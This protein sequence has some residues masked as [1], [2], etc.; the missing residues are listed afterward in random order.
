M[1]TIWEFPKPPEP[2]MTRSER[3]F[4]K[5]LFN[6]DQLVVAIPHLRLVL[7]LLEGLEIRIPEHC[8]DQD[9]DLGL[10]LLELS[11]D[12][13]RSAAGR[14]PLQAYARPENPP[15]DALVTYIYKSCEDQYGEWTPTIGKNRTVAE[16][17]RRHTI[18]VGDEGLPVAVQQPQAA[19]DAHP[20][21]GVA[22]G[23]A[24]TV[25]HGNRWLAGAYQA[26]AADL[27]PDPSVLPGFQSGHATFVTG[28]IL[29]EAP[30]ARV[31]V[32]R[33][34][35]DE[36]I[37]DSWS[38]AKAL[39]GFER[40][41]V[42]VLNLSL[43]CFTDDNK[44]PLVLATALNRLDPDIVVVA[45]AGNHAANVAKRRP[46]Y[47]AAIPRV[48]AVGATNCAGDVPAWSPGSAQWPWLDVLATGDGVISTFPEGRVRMPDGEQEYNGY[49][50]WSGT[51]FAAAKVSGAIAARTVPGR[52]DAAT[53]FRELVGS[54]EKRHDLPWI[55]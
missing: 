25:L 43:G 15:L 12:E 50:R 38:V 44:E 9:P 20:G 37:A 52:I 30:G 17:A 4:G 18:G 14:P 16:V 29:Q 26:P 19:R 2:M 1:L 41:G 40:L 51:S 21:G 36:G 31:E 8:V 11:S 6:E 48:V 32:R 27:W 53:A 54:S 22:V 55:R 24:D 3:T 46:I 45:A 47:P 7:G 34:V 28:M 13:L 35:D 49:A 42:D 23:V 33:V 5:A 10:A 39:V